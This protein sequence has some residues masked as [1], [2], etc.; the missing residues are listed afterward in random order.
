MHI[1]LLNSAP[2]VAVVVGALI[3]ALSTGAKMAEMGRILF[4]AGCFAAL[5][6]L[7]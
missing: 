4:A 2:I 1:T 3:Y 7:R 6:G 5:F